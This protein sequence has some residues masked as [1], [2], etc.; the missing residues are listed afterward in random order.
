MNEHERDRAQSPHAT[1]PPSNSPT[2]AGGGATTRHLTARPTSK[3]PQA[4]PREVQAKLAVQLEES[5]VTRY[6][7]ESSP[8]GIGPVQL[9]RAGAI[10]TSREET[11]S[12]AAGGV[13]GPASSLP[14]GDSIQ[15]SFGH[16]DVS[17]IEAH[18]GGAAGNT[19]E[20]IGATAYAT[21]NHVAFQSA[22]DL[23]T[24]AHE[25][26]HVVQ[27]RGG[28]QLKGGVG[29]SGDVYEQHADAVADKVVRGESAQALLDV[30]AGAAATPPAVQRK[31]TGAAP[32]TG[33]APTPHTSIPMVDS[34]FTCERDEGS[35]CFLSPAQRIQVQ[36]ELIRRL[37]M[38]HSNFQ[39]AASEARVEL[40]LEKDAGWGF[41][42]E[43][44]FNV[45]SF[46]VVGGLMK[47]LSALRKAGTV[48]DALAVMGGTAAEGAVTQSLKESAA[49]INTDM[50]ED[51]LV[52]VAKGVRAQ[53]K[54]SASSIRR[55][56]RG[57]STSSTS[58]AKATKSTLILSHR[59]LPHRSTTRS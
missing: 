50:I 23:H 54:Q 17:G 28:V 59:R 53:V 3:L 45:A 6:G 37:G 40:L 15:R 2:R 51:V 38:E 49:A 29:E 39:V 26:A 42:A 46:T 33:P 34:G 57:A 52:H 10:P 48:K 20:A 32:A 1:Q 9:E 31:A 21:G 27:Q 5:A 35:E 55:T 14:H 56:R 41:V 8:F 25:A 7:F 18:V 11:V 22:P 24:A 30:T 36:V 13:S 43:L 19:A 4:A 16:H 47:G 12:I 58:C 44:L